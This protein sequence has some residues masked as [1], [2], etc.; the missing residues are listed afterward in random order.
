MA[1]VG[2]I[3]VDAAGNYTAIVRGNNSIS[4][5]ALGEEYNLGNPQ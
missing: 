4:G 5:V 3:A 2:A 1:T